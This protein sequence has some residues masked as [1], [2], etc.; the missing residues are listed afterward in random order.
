MIIYELDVPMQP[1]SVGVTVIVAEIAA[2][3]EF[4]AKKLEILPVPDADKLILV[5]LLL[6]EYVAPVGELTKLVTGTVS[7]GQ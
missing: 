1:P 4:V 3:V 5:L 6:H 2:F 7:P